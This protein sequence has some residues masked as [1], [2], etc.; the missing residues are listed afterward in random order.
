MHWISYFW[1]LLNRSVDWETSAVSIS[2]FFI[3]FYNWLLRADPYIWQKP[4]PQRYWRLFLSI[5]MSNWLHEFIEFR[6]FIN[7]YSLWGPQFFVK[8]K[9]SSTYR[10]HRDGFLAVFSS[11]FSPNYSRNK[12]T[13]IV[14]KVIPIANCLFV[15]RTCFAGKV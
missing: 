11:V 8:K 14:S 13:I 9:L 12:I 4:L 3:F 10:S 2:I 5:S 7:L 15:Q 6:W 1:C